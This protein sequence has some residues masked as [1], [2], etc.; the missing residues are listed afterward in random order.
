MK[1]KF[2]ILIY[3]HKKTFF[4]K[5]NILNY[6]IK[7]IKFPTFL[8]TGDN[9]IKHKNV[10]HIKFKECYDQLGLKTYLAFKKV[11]NNNFDFLIKLNDDTFF[12]IDKFLDEEIS[13]YDYIGKKENK[14][15]N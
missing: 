14:F 6:Y 12:D 13:G 2:I 5:Q 8:V 4:K 3:T 9:D 1:N 11:V 7:K 10:L 15:K